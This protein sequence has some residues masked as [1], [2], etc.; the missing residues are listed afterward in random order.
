MVGNVDL[1]YGMQWRVALTLRPGRSVLEQATTLYNPSDTRHRFYWWTNAAVGTWDDSQLVYPMEFTATHGFTQ[2]DTWPVDSSGVD[3]SRPGNH[4]K[5]AVSLFSHGSHEPFMG[6]YHPRTR[7]GV[8]HWADP[9]E[10]PAKKIWSWGADAEGRDWRRA[11]SDDDSAQVEIQAGL[12]RNQETYAFLEPQETI[13]FR[14]HWV[15][16]RAIGGILP[17][18]TG[19]R[20]P[21]RAPDARACCPWAPRSRAVS[22]AAACA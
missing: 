12:F 11:L 14:E 4:R 6:V 16:V 15:P 1:V 8:A 10:L 17:R 2:V 21:H 18:N 19:R 20:R 5:G 3:L 22:P 13:R 7:A 9:A